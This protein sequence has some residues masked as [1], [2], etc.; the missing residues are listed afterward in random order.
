VA[1]DVCALTGRLIRQAAACG[2]LAASWPRATQI[3][4]AIGR[5]H[6]FVR[7]TSPKSIP[8]LQGTHQGR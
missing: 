4:A 2:C 7:L 5:L 8:R 1:Q 6:A 3:T